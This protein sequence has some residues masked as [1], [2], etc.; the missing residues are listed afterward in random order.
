[1]STSF[2]P[3]MALTRADV[4]ADPADVIA[5][6]LAL[7]GVQS[8][9][10]RGALALALV[11]VL[12]YAP[13]TERTRPHAVDNLVVAIAVHQLVW[14]VLSAFRVGGECLPDDLLR[15]QIPSWYYGRGTAA[16]MPL[17]ATQQNT[18]PT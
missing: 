13:T 1:M 7:A 17:C 5:A 4:Y 16:I 14:R 6:D 11:D 10:R 15:Y 3:A 8:G 2:G 12:V 9:A 18:P